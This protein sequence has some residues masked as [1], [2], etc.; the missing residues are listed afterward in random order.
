VLALAD[1]AALRTAAGLGTAAVAA[2]VTSTLPVLRGGSGAS[3]PLD[4]DLTAI[5]ALTTTIFGTGVPRARGRC[6]GPYRAWPGDARDSVGDVLGDEL[7]TNTGDQTSVSGNAGTATAL[8]T[9]RAIDGQTFDG[10]AAITVIAP[11]THAATGKTTPVDAD[12]IP[13]V[14]SAASNVLKKLTW[15]NLKATLKTYF[16]TLYPSGSGTSTGTNTGDQTISDATISTSDI[17]TNNVSS[18][19]HGFVPETPKRRNEVPRRHGRV[20]Y[21]G[22]THI[23]FRLYVRFGRH[24]LVYIYRRKRQSTAG[25]RVCTPEEL[26][27]ARQ[28]SLQSKQRHRIELLQHGRLWVW[29]LGHRSG[30]TCRNF[31]HHRACSGEYRY[32]FLGGWFRDVHSELRGHNFHEARV[33][34]FLR[35]RRYVLRRPACE[36]DGL[37]LDLC[38]GDHTTRLFRGDDGELCNRQ[39]DHRLHP[40]KGRHSARQAIRNVRGS[41]PVHSGLTGTLGVRITDNV[42]ATTTARVTAG[43]A[44]YPAGSGIYEVTLTAPDDRGQYSLVWDD[45]TNYAIDELVVT[46]SVTGAV[47][48]DTYATVDELFRILK[49]RNATADQTDAG[50]RVL[51][52]AAQEIDDEIDLADDVDLTDRQLAI[53]AQVNLDRAADLWRH[54]ESIPG[55]TGLLGDDGSVALPGRYSWNRYAE[56]LAGC[57]NQWGLA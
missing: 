39:P 27:A 44:E 1:A 8:A 33:C 26:V 7:G 49:I 13:L 55:I 20:L 56:R 15:A 50:E 45:G 32:R 47:A 28:P 10:T 24:V 54:T 22:G 11:G 41:R 43:I 17:T 29:I 53:A 48:G 25:S 21:P 52:A 30:S 57:K 18:S 36:D 2:P 51:L 31:C 37:H 16:D 19:K 3:Q 14:D 23:R 5:A 42:G 9:G 46:S 35:A 38:V 12:E 4:S 6:S 40:L 34:S